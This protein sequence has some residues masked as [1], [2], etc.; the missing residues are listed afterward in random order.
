MDE[1]CDSLREQRDYL[2]EERDTMK[3]EW[4]KALK[5]YE[6]QKIKSVSDFNKIVIEKEP[7]L[8]HGHSLQESLNILKAE[9]CS[10]EDVYDNWK[11]KKSRM[12]IIR[13]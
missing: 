5:L 7:L 6:S 2:K 9:K 12:R 8:A 10:I 11:V 4:S 13:P 3:T 1:Q